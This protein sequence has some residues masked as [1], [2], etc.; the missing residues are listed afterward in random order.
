MEMFGTASHI[1]DQCKVFYE[2]EDG[3]IWQREITSRHN[4][5]KQS[6]VL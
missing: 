4:R 5:V 1:T 3:E 6:K 2:I